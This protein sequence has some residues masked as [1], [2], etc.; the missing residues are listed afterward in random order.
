[1]L[2]PQPFGSIT[3][4]VEKDHPVDFSHFNIQGTCIGAV[5]IEADPDKATF[6]AVDLSTEIGAGDQ[7][8]EV[9]KILG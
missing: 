9:K 2:Y 4:E 1:M 7:K 5:G 6:P 3:V 8:T